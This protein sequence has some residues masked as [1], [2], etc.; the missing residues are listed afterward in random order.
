ML[1]SV[2]SLSALHT[3]LKVRFLFTTFKWMMDFQIFAGKDIHSHVFS[4]ETR[5]S[6][7][8]P[9]KKTVDEKNTSPATG[10]S[11]LQHSASIVYLIARSGKQLNKG[12]FH[13]PSS[14]VRLCSVLN[15]ATGEW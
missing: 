14:D 2:C 9:A 8:R 11:T 13:I 3:Q 15:Y 5:V 6:A 7:K 4:D 12:N 1:W 10:Q